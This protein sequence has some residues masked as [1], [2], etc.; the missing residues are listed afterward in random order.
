MKK[1]LISLILLSNIAFAKP[2]VSKNGIIKNNKVI[3]AVIDK[4]YTR[5]VK[6]IKGT[7]LINMGKSKGKLKGT[8][9]AQIITLTIRN[10]FGEWVKNDFELYIVEDSDGN[11]T[12]AATVSSD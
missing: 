3:Q 5:K 9:W 10:P 4:T 2:V 7:A 8:I 6:F 12:F 1:L 11:V